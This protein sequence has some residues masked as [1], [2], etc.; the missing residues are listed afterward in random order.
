[1]NRY[2]DLLAELIP[3]FQRSQVIIQDPNEWL[4]QEPTEPDN[5]IDTDIQQWNDD[6]E[7]DDAANFEFPD[8]SDV[9]DGE[10]LSEEEDNIAEFV[11]RDLERLTN[12]IP[13]DK[14]FDIRDGL[15][16]LK[17]RIYFITSNY[18]IRDNELLIED[19]ISTTTAMLRQI[20]TPTQF[21]D[22]TIGNLKEHATILPFNYR[23]G[24]GLNMFALALAILS[25][26]HMGLEQVYKL[27]SP[28]SG[29]YKIY[30]PDIIRY[31]S[32]VR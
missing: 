14:M 15:S 9:L 8:E 16:Q 7:P 4:I 2:D 26:K 24:V 27:W 10:V 5:I 13:N 1:M 23:E 3:D 29:T 17:S 21:I 25:K 32:Y 18:Q 19:M 20:N 11:Y 22:L 31:F 6:D 28:H 12:Q 30:K